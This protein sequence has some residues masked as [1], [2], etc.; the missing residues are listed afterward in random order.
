MKLN[1]ITIG[2]PIDGLKEQHDYLRKYDGHFNTVIKLIKN[3]QNEGI[4]YNLHTVVTKL[5]INNLFQLAEF[6]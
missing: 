2:L 5:N 6:I 4:K 3:F 1:N